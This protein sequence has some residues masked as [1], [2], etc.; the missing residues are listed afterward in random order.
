MTRAKGKLLLLPNVLGGQRDHSPFLPVS[1]DAA[2]ATLDGLIAESFPEG[3]SFLS[4]FQTKKRP[5][6]TPMAE[7][8]GRTPREDMDFLLEPVLKGECWGLVVDAGLPCI[9][10]PGSMLVAR[11]RHL[12][13]EIEAYTGPSSIMLSLMLSGFS[14]QNFSFCGY[15]DKTPE[16]RT[17][18]LL[19]L[20]QRSKKESST[21][22]FIEAP[23]RNMHALQTSIECLEPKTLLCVAWDLT[24]PTQGVISQTVARWKNTPLPDL[25]KKP[26]IFLLAT[27][28]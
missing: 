18:E 8:N 5:Q 28:G 12:G 6:D 2:V 22:I 23:Y 21:Q 3:R 4:R 26:S 14:G 19:Q 16:G 20:E 10:D 24:L 13:V 15:L 27:S 25:L 7:L 1:V 9:A 17:R 11:A